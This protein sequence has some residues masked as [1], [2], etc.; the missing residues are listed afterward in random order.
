MPPTSSASCGSILKRA[1]STRTGPRPIVPRFTERNLIRAIEGDVYPYWR[2]DWLSMLTNLPIMMMRIAAILLLTLAIAGA[3]MNVVFPWVNSANGPQQVRRMELFPIAVNGTGPNGLTTL[4][5]IS[6]T[7]DMTGSVL[8]TNLL[9][10]SYMAVFYGNTICTTQWF[11][12]SPFTNGTVN[13]TNYVTG[14]NTPPLVVGFS[15]SAS[16][17]TTAQTLAGTN[18]ATVTPANGGF[19]VSPLYQ[20]FPLPG[21]INRP[22]GIA[23][24]T[25]PSLNDLFGNTILL[26]GSNQTFTVR[27]TNGNDIAYFST[28]NSGSK[29][30]LATA[31]GESSTAGAAG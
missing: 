8:F 27:D 26:T 12:F 28:T 20:S 15:L 23:S 13:A 19:V 1:S 2:D 25:Y 17:A 30:H 29:P 4:D 10:G 31:P 18:G 11:S 22:V 5:R 21:F 3:Q 24:G 7:T 6:K 14:T 16:N 9:P